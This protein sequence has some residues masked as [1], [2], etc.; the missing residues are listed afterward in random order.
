MGTPLA[1]VAGFVAGWVTRSTVDPAKSTTVQIVAFGID[2]IARVKR[3]LAIERERFE[4][5]V[6]EASDQVARR[7]AAGAEPV[8][9]L[10]PQTAPA[11]GNAA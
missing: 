8:E 5:L 11:V 4:D 10:E 7:R 3:M 6:A 9:D 1:F 2:V